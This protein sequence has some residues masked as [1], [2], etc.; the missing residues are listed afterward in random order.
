[1]NPKSECWKD[2]V[3]AAVNRKE[4]AWKGVLGAKDEIVKEICNKIYKGE[5]KD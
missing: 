4:G 5:E 2:V 1:M 3:K